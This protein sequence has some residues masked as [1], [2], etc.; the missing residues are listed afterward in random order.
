MNKPRTPSDPLAAQ[1]ISGRIK[2]FDAGRGF[3]FILP[4]DP[5]TRV[6]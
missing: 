3:G 6:G 2:W 5:F 1:G 4:D